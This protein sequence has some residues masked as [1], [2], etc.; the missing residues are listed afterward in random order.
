LVSTQISLTILYIEEMQMIRGLVI[1]SC[2]ANLFVTNVHGQIAPTPAVTA[3]AAP[4]KD[5]LPP[6]PTNYFNDYAQVTSAGTQAALEKELSDFDQSTA[7]HVMVA[8][9]KHKESPLNLADYCTR[10]ANK[11]GVGQKGK[12][13][14]VV[15]FVFTEDHLMR[16]TTGLSTNPPLTSQQAQ[17]ILDKVIA[18]YFRKQDFQ[19]GISYGVYEILHTIKV[20]AIH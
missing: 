3:A 10:V 19:S 15:L 11:W 16:I 9:F 1:I 4:A 14:G 7:N 20:N 13:N 12:N 17:S 8:I 2:L 5:T 18:P 6:T